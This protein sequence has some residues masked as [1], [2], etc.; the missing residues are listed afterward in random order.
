MTKNEV[1]PTNGLGGVWLQ[2]DRQMKNQTKS[3]T[4]E[5]RGKMGMFRKKRKID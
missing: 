3:D 1:N 5:I 4:G 2:T